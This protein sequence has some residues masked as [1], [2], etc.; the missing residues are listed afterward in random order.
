MAVGDGGDIGDAGGA[1]SSR[2]ELARMT[3]VLIG[4]FRHTRPWACT[5][6]ACTPAACTPA[7]WHTR[8]WEGGGQC[9]HERRTADCSW[10]MR[11]HVA[12]YT[13]SKYDGRIRVGGASEAVGN[14][15]G[16]GYGDGYDSPN[17]PIPPPPRGESIWGDV[18]RCEES[19]WG[20]PDEMLDAAKARPR[21]SPHSRT[22]RPSRHSPTGALSD[23]D[24]DELLGGYTGAY[25]GEY[26]DEDDRYEDDFLSS[27]FGYSGRPDRYAVEWEDDEE[28][29]RRIAAH[30]DESPLRLLMPSPP[31]HH[32]SRA[33]A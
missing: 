4:A 25:C 28:E 27:A 7:G 6:A 8:P 17:A 29:E 10:L 19:I 9:G 23:D 11:S 26:G 13:Y 33:V 22:P 30:A 18:G 3:S 20:T 16:D 2:Q 14:P 32:R 24:D 5:P 12:G 31:L 21:V 1:G 15:E